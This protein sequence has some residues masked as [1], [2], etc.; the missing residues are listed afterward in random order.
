M[1]VTMLFAFTRCIQNDAV[2]SDADG[3][4]LVLPDGFEAEVVVDSIGPARHMTVNENGDLYVKLRHHHPDGSVLVLQDTTDDG[5]ADVTHRFH[6]LGEDEGSY[7][8]GVEIYDDHLYV[9][10]DLTVWR[11]AL[12]PGE[13][14]PEGDPVVVAR[15]DHDH[16]LHEHIGKP[17]TFDN[18]GNLYVP[19]GAPSD[20]CQEENRVPGSPGMD[21]CPQLEEHAGIWQFDHDGTEQTQSD[22]VHFATGLRSVVAMDWNSVDDN[23]YVAVHGRDYLHRNWPEMYSAWD[24]AVLPSEEFA[25][26]SEGSDFGWPYCYYDQRLEQK[27]LAPEY[28]GD[29]EAVERCST[30]DDPLI[31][32]PG[33]LAPND[34]MFYQGEQFPD[35]YKAGA[36]IAF[37]G[38]TIRDP[39]PQAGYFVA[40][41]PFD[42]GEPSG[43]WEVFANGFAGVDP[44]ESTGDARHRP[45]GLAT[46]PDGSIYISESNEGKI[47]RITYTGDKEAF[48]EADLA[49][50]E[51]EKRSASNIRTPDED[52]DNLQQDALAAGEE[53]FNTYCASC[54]GRDGEGSPPR[55][56]AIRGTDAVTGDRDMLISTILNGIDGPTQ[57]PPH[58]FL[59]DEQ[60]AELV[61]YVRQNFGNDVNPVSPEEVEEVREASSED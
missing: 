56:P 16:G 14:V 22:G 5:K 30:F 47:W 6:D 15:D 52:E 9:S 20:V 49:R 41:V 35:H 53:T 34:L 19:F 40:F 58:D 37:H 61:T 21:P 50:V 25:R 11:Y 17:I 38:S 29:G 39:F 60:V 8:S 10:S 24:N 45:V 7:Q 55:Y 57:M 3:P 43:D 1:V 44:I 4:G 23:L 2:D 13:V 59:T 33:H 12:S 48:G 27:V 32:F 26:V 51:D 46:A 31:G 36:F 28:G 42:K 18:E 54:H